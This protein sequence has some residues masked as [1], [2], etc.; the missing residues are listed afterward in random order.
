M[1]IVC[2][3]S[4]NAYAWTTLQGIGHLRKICDR[5]HTN[6]S[7]IRFN[8]CKDIGFYECSKWRR[9]KSVDIFTTFGIEKNIVLYSMRYTIYIMSTVLAVV[10][11][12]TACSLGNG[13]TNYTPEIRIANGLTT[14]GDTITCRYSTS[15]NYY[16]SDTLNMGDT[17]NFSFYF[18]SYG[19]ML[20]AC[21]ISCDEEMGKLLFA[22]QESLDSVF[23][24]D[25]SDYAKGHFVLPS[26]GY[27]MAVITASY[28]PLKAASD[29]FI[30][31]G[32][33]SD[34]QYSPRNTHLKLPV[35]KSTDGEA[36]TDTNE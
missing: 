15:S 12:C 7:S 6:D 2:F 25:R 35:A 18:L 4:S 8:R 22:P 14:K 19:N 34:S 16:V 10:S 26:D 9:K 17:V 28:I 33:T 32:V 36:D 20:I 21:D 30:H 29:G 1:V 5:C 31:L 24:S 11:L 27:S 3:N 23:V 13:S